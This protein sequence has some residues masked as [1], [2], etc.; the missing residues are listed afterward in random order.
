MENKGYVKNK[1]QTVLIELLKDHNLEDISITMVCKM[2]QVSRASFYRNYTSL[3][4][5]IVKANKN[6][7]STIDINQRYFDFDKVESILYALATH[8][9]LYRDYYS[10]L[11][12]RKL[13]NTILIA[14]KDLLIKHEETKSNKD[15]YLTAFI[16][17]GIHGIIYSWIRNGMQ[18]T[19]KELGLTIRN[20]ES[21]YS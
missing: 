2:S 15:K 16:F 20:K 19:P 6:L 1:L 10:L 4:D 12:R 5:I 14:L 3:E 17:F 8:A 11:H 13:N 21:L 9:I 7:L 18:E